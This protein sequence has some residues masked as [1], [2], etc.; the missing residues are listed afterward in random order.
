MFINPLNPELNPIC[1]LLALLGA[2]HFL[3][4]SRLRVILVVNLVGRARSWQYTVLATLRQCYTYWKNLLPVSL[5]SL[6]GNG[7]RIISGRVYLHSKEWLC[8]TWFYDAFVI[9]WNHCGMQFFIFIFEAMCEVQNVHITSLTSAR[10]TVMSAQY[11]KM[12]S[13]NYDEE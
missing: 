3:H 10:W 6:D 11:N 7:T 13:R 12:T 2:H 4:V 9:N 5:I 1:Y 8:F